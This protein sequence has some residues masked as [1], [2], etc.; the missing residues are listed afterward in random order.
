MI[1]DRYSYLWPPRP[2]RAVDK[3][4]LTV[5]EERNFSAQV[6][7]NGTCSVIF[8]AP[9]KSIVAMT[10]HNEPH[11]KWAPTDHGMSAFT[12]LSG[13]G[14]YV[15]VAELLH[16][17]VPGLRDINYVHDILVMDGEYLVGSTQE[18]RQDI[19]HDL[20]IKGGEEETLSHIV[21]N[22]NLWLAI[23]YEEDF[24]NL[25]D[26]LSKPED[27]GIV[28]KDPKRPLALCSRSSSNSL[29]L[30][31]CRRPHDNYSF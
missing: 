29:G 20:F 3:S 2:E 21:I 18:Q 12:A 27:E 22:P 6:K 8:V 7:K 1:Y 10:R 15:F 30:L 23:E 19:L 25:F 5:F 13:Q 11:R 31:K 28:L 16:S 26:S 4:L 9:D 14:W 17:K 24:V